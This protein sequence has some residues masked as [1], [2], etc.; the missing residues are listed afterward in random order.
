M[1]MKFFSGIN[2]FAK[3]SFFI[4]SRIS[5]LLIAYLFISNMVLA[6]KHVVKRGEHLSGISQKY[7]VSVK[8]LMK[9]N[10]IRQKNKIFI[11]Q[12]LIIPKRNST[13]RVPYRRSPTF[14]YPVRKVRILSSFG[15]GNETESF[16]LTLSTHRGQTIRASGRGRI[17]RVGRFRGLGDYILIDHGGGW[18]TMYSGFHSV[19][20]RVGEKVKKNS[21]LGNLRGN[22]LFFLVAYRGIPVDPRR[23][24]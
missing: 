3:N 7:S 5:A 1:P 15:R 21:S 14:V 22:H 11:G 13:T 2:I 12:K 4:M 17:A 18:I 19:G 20:V 16:G 10:S 23:V 24:M 8:K 6:R 9:V